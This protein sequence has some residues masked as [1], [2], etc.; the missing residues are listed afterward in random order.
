MA[1][2]LLGKGANLYAKDNEGKTPPEVANNEHTVK[3]LKSLQDKWKTLSGNGSKASS[4]TAG[5]E[6]K[7]VDATSE[8]LDDDDAAD[9]VLAAGGTTEKVL[10]K[11]ITA[12]NETHKAQMIDLERK[13]IS[14]IT[15]LQAFIEQQNKQTKVAQ[16]KMTNLIQEQTERQFHEMKMLEEKNKHITD[17]VE[18]LLMQQ[19]FESVAALSMDRRS[20][21][22]SASSKTEEVLKSLQYLILEQ[23]KT[24]QALEKKLTAT[25]T[26]QSEERRIVD[27]A[28]AE[29]QKVELGHNVKLLEKLEAF[30]EAQHTEL[31][32]SST[33][34]IDTPVTGPIHA[35]LEKLLEKQELLL[36]ALNGKALGMEFLQVSLAHCQQVGEEQQQEILAKKAEIDFLQAQVHQYEEKEQKERLIAENALLKEKLLKFEQANNEHNT[37]ASLQQQV[38]A[39]KKELT[40]LRKGGA[41]ASTG[42]DITGIKAPMKAR[43]AGH[44]KASKA[45]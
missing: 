16:M 21:Q 30:L 9:R 31:N 37:V 1:C 24:I 19:Q 26:L 36:T 33:S 15:N 43:L 35:K 14:T 18:Q 45:V 22:G 44:W 3:A 6:K 17:K 8:S 40:A 2:L 41:G 23:T 27:S 13:S 38:E 7:E 11:L 29:L 25:E 20:S 42:R 39:Q 12:Q 5:E 4:A 10:Q 28:Q 32:D 34:S